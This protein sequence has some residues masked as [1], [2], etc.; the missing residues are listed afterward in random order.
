V[1]FRSPVY[2]KYNNVFRTSKKLVPGNLEINM[3]LGPQQ[4]EDVKEKK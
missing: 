3:V 2:V 4:I 1:L